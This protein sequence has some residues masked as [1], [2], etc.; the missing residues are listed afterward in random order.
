[1]INTEIGLILKWSQNCVLTEKVTRQLSARIAGLSV[2]NQAN[3]I[4]RP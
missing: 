2:F 4:N 1:M 3:V